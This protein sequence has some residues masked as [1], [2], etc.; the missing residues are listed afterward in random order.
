M[1]CRS[2]VLAVVPAFNE[3]LSVGEVV[4]ALRAAAYDVVV[5]DDGSSDSTAA[6]AAEAGAAVVSLAENVGVG[7]ALQTGFRW[8][9]SSGYR[10]V[11]Q[12][13]AD[14]Q[15]EPAEIARLLEAVSSPEES[16]LVIGSRF[17]ERGSWRGLP[18]SRRVAMRSLCLLATRK[19]RV[20]VTDASSGFRLIQGPLLELFAASYPSEYLGDTVEAIVIARRHGAVVREVPVVMHNRL[21]GSSSASAARAT[22][23]V[24]RVAV[25]ILLGADSRRRY[26]GP[27][28]RL[29]PLARAGTATAS[30][31]RLSRPGQ[32]G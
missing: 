13:D 10:R 16:A 30:C 15:H 7:A 1:V 11:V 32:H 5:V 18:L 22:W 27:P 14:G 29:S 12:C 17:V 25:A 6:V 3:E 26:I 21:H 8:A 19:S 2:G 23:Y 9:V 24:A 4:A 20:A 31:G 28:P